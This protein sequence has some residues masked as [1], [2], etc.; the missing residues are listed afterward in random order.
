MNRLYSD[1]NKILDKNINYYLYCAGG[2]RSHISYGILRR[3]DFN[4]INILGGYRALIKEGIKILK[5]I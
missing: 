4:V 5:L 2:I 3:F 1:A